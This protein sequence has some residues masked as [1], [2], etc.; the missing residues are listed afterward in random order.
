MERGNGV[1]VGDWCG[2]GVGVGNWCGNGVGVGDWYIR[3][4]GWEWRVSMVMGC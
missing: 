2:N 1:G 4:M 3:L